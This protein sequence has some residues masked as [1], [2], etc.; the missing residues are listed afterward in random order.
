M[1]RR[2]PLVEA[3]VGENADLVR[4][5]L[6]NGAPADQA[7]DQGTTALML[8]CHKGHM[9]CVRALLEAGAQVAQAQQ[10]GFTALLVA[11][12]KGHMACMHALLEA[13]AP[14]E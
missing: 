11:C 13:G 6:E 4:T 14:V 12:G 8:A 5:L 2:A 9:Y 10:D 3:V 7:D 1:N